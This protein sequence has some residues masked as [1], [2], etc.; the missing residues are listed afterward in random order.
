MWKFT[1]DKPKLT[2]YSNLE[3]TGVT[4]WASVVVKKA[5]SAG[6]E[7]KALHTHSGML[8]GEVSMQYSEM[9]SSALTVHGD[10]KL[11][12]GIPAVCDTPGV[13]E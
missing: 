9:N 2:A 10:G 3:E 1:L 11:A 8:N 7:F 4:E 6:S 5:N 12:A 13:A